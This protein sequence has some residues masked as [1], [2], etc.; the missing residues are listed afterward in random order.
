M[1]ISKSYLDDLAMDYF[2]RKWSELDICD[3]I[4]MIHYEV[5]IRPKLEI[6]K[7]EADNE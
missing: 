7:Q 3:K 6:I 4:D 2:G 1:V 5:C